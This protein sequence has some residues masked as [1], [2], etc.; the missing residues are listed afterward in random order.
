MA[1]L[2][3][4]EDA[5]SSAKNMGRALLS[6]GVFKPRDEPLKLTELVELAEQ[7]QMSPAQLRRLEW[8]RKD[9]QCPSW[10]G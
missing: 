1:K 10:W 4:L 8:V 9:D 6:L 7:L 5:Y 3:M 2:F